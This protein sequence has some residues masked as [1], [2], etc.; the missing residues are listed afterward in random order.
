[1]LGLAGA[2]AST[3]LLEGWLYGVT[4]LDT[5][6]FAWS[7]AAMLLIAGLASYLPARRATRIDPLVTL[8][9]E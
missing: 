8:K 2:A 1:V 4:P 5:G 9:A 3:R 6:T 7:A